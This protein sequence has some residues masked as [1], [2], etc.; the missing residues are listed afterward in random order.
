MNMRLV[1]WGAVAME[2]ARKE[3]ISAGKEDERSMA[4]AKSMSAH[5]IETTAE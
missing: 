1:R 4:L 3:G 2:A 5:P